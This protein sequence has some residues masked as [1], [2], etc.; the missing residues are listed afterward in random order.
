[1]SAEK[2]I[3]YSTP[4]VQAYFEDRKTCTRRVIKP[5]PPK[6][7]DVFA[8]FAP[9]IKEGKAPEGCWYED[10]DGLKFHCKCPYGQVGDVL[11]VNETWAAEKMFDAM[12]PK[13][14]ET[15]G[16]GT[17]PLWYKTMD[18]QLDREGQ[19]RGRWRSGRFMPKWA[20]RLRQTITDI[21]VERLQEITEEDA[22][23]EGV[24]RPPNY[25]LTPYYKEWFK[26]L[27]NTIYKRNNRWQ[28]NPWV[29][30]LSYPKYS[31][32]R[33]RSEG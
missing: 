2:P 24:T 23:A 30:V 11:R 31:E 26:Y 9:E 25:S 4:M 19:I 8:W 1:M 14:I 12:S 10:K 21:R 17:V 15:T 22:E 13:E 32:E 33:R 29:F 6:D 20:C 27:W 18:W 16:V 7:A 28:D 3:L 5:Q